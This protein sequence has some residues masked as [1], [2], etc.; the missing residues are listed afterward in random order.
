MD[1]RSLTHT[2]KEPEAQ[3]WAKIGTSSYD[4][5]IKPAPAIAMDKPSTLATT[6]ENGIPREIIT[7]EKA[8]AETQEPRKETEGKAEE[9]GKAEEKKGNSPPKRKSNTLGDG[10]DTNESESKEK[11]SRSRSR[12]RER[13]RRSPEKRSD[14]STS[15]MNQRD[16]RSR[17]FIGHLNT[18]ECSKKDIEEV[19]GPYGKITG[20]N[21]QNGYGFVQYDNEE[22]VKEAI[23]KCH[24]TTFMGSRIGS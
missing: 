1:S 5:S 21:L 13:R 7:Q 19:F 15:S 8:T 6:K 12:S 23:K 14:Y 18:S 22:S 11:R 10:F 2:S 20:I 3:V 17:V 16:I 4:P 24:N 9:N